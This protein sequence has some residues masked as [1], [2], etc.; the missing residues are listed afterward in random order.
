M[1]S[2]QPPSAVSYSSRFTRWFFRSSTNLRQAAAEDEVKEIDSAS[3]ITQFGVP[4]KFDD[5]QHQKGI[6]SNSWFNNSD[7]QHHHHSNH[8]NPH[9]S[10]NKKSI[11]RIASVPNAKNMLEAKKAPPMP[12][13]NNN[14]NNNDIK[15]SP[16]SST[17]TLATSRVPR[18]NLHR[19]ETFKMNR[20]SYAAN[21]VKIREVQ[22]G[23]SRCVIIN[24]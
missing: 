5:V 22:V 15:P 6:K 13:Y 23:P 19:S 4:S 12:S 1:E 8:N 24:N 3:S 21:S 20:R 16:L 2:A 11:R 9:N 7:S 14:N 10:I 17:T 18:Q